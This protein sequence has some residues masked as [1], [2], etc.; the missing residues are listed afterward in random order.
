[1]FR[2]EK[3]HMVTWLPTRFY[4]D[5][6]GLFAHFAPFLWVLGLWLLLGMQGHAQSCPAA[7]A[8]VLIDETFS[9][10]GQAP[11]LN[12]RTDYSLANT[13]CPE[14]GQYL[15]VDQLLNRCYGV[16]HLLPEDHT[17][18]D[19]NGSMLI[20]NS[21]AVPGAFYQQTLAGLCS[22][23]TYEFSVWAI[24]LVKTGTCPNPLV[25]NLTIRIETETGQVLS[26]V[27]IGLIA[28]TDT[29]I[30]QRFSATFT[31][32]NADEPV[33]VKLINQQGEEGCGN[34]MA[35]DDIQLLRCTVCPPAP[36]FVPEA[37]SPNNDAVNDKL[38]I[39][40]RGAVNL[41]T[42]IYDRWGTLVFNGINPTDQWDGSYRGVPCV[43]G[44]YTWEVAYDVANSTRSTSTY[45]RTGRVLL[46]R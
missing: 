4:P 42:H 36:A 22:G 6:R 34:D 2:G 25:P 1:M 21:S 8:E 11:S 27:D 37:F 16:W 41:R 32:P 40:V 31:T 35:I 43:T 29:P 38:A 12:G 30:W 45:T 19:V 17:I 28:D 7:T 33:L 26:R 46:V 24:N 39:F 18:G 5:E 15:L 14:A 20:V 3:W 13:P 23:T 44:Y 9:T 10:A